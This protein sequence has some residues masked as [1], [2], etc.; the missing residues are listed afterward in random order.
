M[1]ALSRTAARDRNEQGDGVLR[2]VDKPGSCTYAHRYTTPGIGVQS[3]AVSE[4][5]ELPSITLRVK[6]VEKPLLGTTFVG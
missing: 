5:E 2:G 1:F 4:R 6:S 3:R